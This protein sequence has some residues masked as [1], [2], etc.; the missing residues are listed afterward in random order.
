MGPPACLPDGRRQLIRL[1]GRDRSQ[2]LTAP[3]MRTSV[4]HG[5]IAY[6]QNVEIGFSSWLG[7]NSCLNHFEMAVDRWL[8]SDYGPIVSL[9]PDAY[10]SHLGSGVEISHD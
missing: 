8:S 5:G 9:N 7:R 4:S 2:D 1:R 10:G 6:A 3:P